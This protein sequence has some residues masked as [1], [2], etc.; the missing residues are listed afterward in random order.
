MSTGVDKQYLR[1]VYGPAEAW[2]TLPE[3]TTVGATSQFVGFSVGY[4]SEHL[5]RPDE[6]DK[7]A[8]LLRE[9]AARSRTLAQEIADRP[10]TRC[11]WCGDNCPRFGNDVCP[12]RPQQLPRP[13][14]T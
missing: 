12:M 10:S 4:G 13:E 9:A 1:N 3:G 7:I 8:D 5:L 2:A 14:E 6:A 11:R